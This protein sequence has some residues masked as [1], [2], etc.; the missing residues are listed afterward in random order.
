MQQR[1]ALKMC[2]ESEGRVRGIIF[3][4]IKKKKKKKEKRLRAISNDDDCAR[5]RPFD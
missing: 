4:I 3:L 2:A 1:T 5:H